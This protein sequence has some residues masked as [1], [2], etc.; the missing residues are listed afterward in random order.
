MIPLPTLLLVL[1]ADSSLAVIPLP[2][3]VTRGTGAFVVTGR[4]WS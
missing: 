1:A 4:R 2:V 3:H